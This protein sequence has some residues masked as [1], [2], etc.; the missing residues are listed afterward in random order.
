MA[1]ADEQEYRMGVPLCHALTRVPKGT[2]C[3]LQDYYICP[4]IKECNSV[5]EPSKKKLSLTKFIGKKCQHLC[6][7]IDL[8]ENIF[9]D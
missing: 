4:K 7:Y 5:F 9:Y 2:V 6:L 1:A 3:Q 8:Y